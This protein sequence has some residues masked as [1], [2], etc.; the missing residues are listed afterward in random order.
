SWLRQAPR[1]NI[2]GPAGIQRRLCENCRPS[3]AGREPARGER[4]ERESVSPWGPS[5]TTRDWLNRAELTAP[6]LPGPVR[7]LQGR[8]VLRN[9]HD[10]SCSPLAAWHGR[11]Q[12][13]SGES[14]EPTCYS[15]KKDAH[16]PEAPARN[17]PRWRFGLV[18]VSHVPE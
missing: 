16:K 15:G 2:P 3:L 14:E 13:A 10:P 12:A 18:C 1:D 7:L 8:V 11:C 4:S 9:R 17:V 5:V 6:S